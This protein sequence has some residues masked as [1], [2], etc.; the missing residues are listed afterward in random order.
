MAIIFRFIQNLHPIKP[1]T[2]PL[3]VHH[4]II[5]EIASYACVC[6]LVRLDCNIA[7][8]FYLTSFPA[9]VKA[10]STQ[11][12]GDRLEQKIP[13]HR[14]CA[15]KWVWSCGVGEIRAL[16]TMCHRLSQLQIEEEL[17]SAIYHFTTIFV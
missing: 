17:A 15:L 1:W 2:R 10:I 13:L 8:W 6:S 16:S 3:F 5:D 12:T 7:G 4:H 11:H 9:H 14:R